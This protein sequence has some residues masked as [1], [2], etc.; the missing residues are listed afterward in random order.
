M[1]DE[2]AISISTESICVH[3]CGH[4]SETTLRIAIPKLIDAWDASNMKPSL[5]V[6]KACD[7]D[8]VMNYVL[9]RKVFRGTTS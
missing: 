7:L 3:E 1:V 6:E 5:L 4:Y 9:F 2:I 8:V